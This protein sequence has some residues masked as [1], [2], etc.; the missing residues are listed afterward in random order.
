MVV[1]GINFSFRNFG[2]M[3]QEIPETNDQFVTDDNKDDLL[4]LLKV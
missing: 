2:L 4:V 3:E 1:T